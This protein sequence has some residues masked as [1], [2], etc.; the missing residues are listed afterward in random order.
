MSRPTPVNTIRQIV[1]G[2]NFQRE[3]TAEE[4][5][6]MAYILRQEMNAGATVSPLA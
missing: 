2:A 6:R 1:M 3:A 5:G 4:V